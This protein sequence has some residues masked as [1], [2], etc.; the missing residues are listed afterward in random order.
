MFGKEHS[1]YGTAWNP[2]SLNCV[3]DTKQLL[4][5]NY[6]RTSNL[7]LSSGGPNMH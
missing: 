5:C 2:C 3:V 1:S 4:S 6:I 7:R